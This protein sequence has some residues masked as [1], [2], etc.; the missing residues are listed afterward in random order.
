MEKFTEKE[1]RQA[2]RFALTG[3]PHGLP[4]ADLIFI[5]GI[6]S[7]VS[8]LENAIKQISDEE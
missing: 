4:V 3:S 2:V 8:R 5:L 1:L 7:T 6:E